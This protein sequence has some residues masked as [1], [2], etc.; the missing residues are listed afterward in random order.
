MRESLTPLMGDLSPDDASLLAKLE[1]LWAKQ[2]PSGFARE[3]EYSL[4]QVPLTDYLAHWAENSPNKDAIIFKGYSLSYAQLHQRSD[5]LAWAMQQQGVN[6]GDR[7]AVFLPNCTQ[8]SVIFYA[9]LKLGAVYVPVSPLSKSFELTHELV[10]AGATW[11]FVWDELLPQVIALIDSLQLKR[12]WV[13]SEEDLPWLTHGVENDV[14][15]QPSL[16]MSKV[17]SF[18]DLLAGATSVASFPRHCDLDAMAALNYT[19][20]TTGLPKGCIHTQRDMIYTAASSCGVALANEP[21]TVILSFFLQSWIAG[22]NAGLIFPVFMGKTLVLLSRW[23][24]QDVLRCV[25][26]YQVTSMVM[27]VDSAQELMDH[28]LFTQLNIRSLRYPRVVSFMKKLSLEDR[29]RWRDL[30]GTCLVES[31]WGLTETHTSDTFTRGLQTDDFDLKST[32]VFIGLPV[33]GT[34]IMAR[35]FDTCVALPLGEAGELCIRSP[36]IFKAYWGQPEATALAFH[37]GWF[38]TGD[39]GMVDEQGFVHYLGRRKEMIKVSGMSVFPM[40]IET[41]LGQ[42]NEVHASGVVALL[43]ESKGEVPV[44]F[45]QRKDSRIDAPLDQALLQWCR[46]RLSS[47]KVPQLVLVRKLPVTAVGK[48]DKKILQKWLESGVPE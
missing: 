10:D 2:W 40:E 27:T 41:V 38:R 25:A 20:G 13:T 46:D 9:L 15:T 19:G 12:I 31:A 16:D 48:V 3:P 5:E 22:E 44:A 1:A 24:A 11:M 30:Q 34:A 4:G 14:C 29:K 26:N 23:D 6:V 8:F 45:V 47:Y 39:S 35:D 18:S 32:P 21:D 42:H 17:A 36:S 37:Q 7:V 33:A 43:D 28:P